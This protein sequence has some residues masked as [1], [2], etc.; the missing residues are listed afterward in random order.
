[1]D[2]TANEA[3]DRKPLSDMKWWRFALV[4][5]CR[6]PLNEIFSRVIGRA[7]ERGFINSVQ[8][9]EIHGIWNRMVNGA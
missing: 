3:F 5:L 9:H 1:M 8:M 2:Q 7:Y 4:Q 6:K